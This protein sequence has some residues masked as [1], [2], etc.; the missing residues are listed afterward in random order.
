MEA[1]E[2]SAKVSRPRVRTWCSA[3]ATFVYVSVADIGE[4]MLPYDPSRTASAIVPTIAA[5]IVPLRDFGRGPGLHVRIERLEDAR[6]I[7]DRW[8]VVVCR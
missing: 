2:K 6:R 1:T 7:G 3:K 5:P 8:D 4:D